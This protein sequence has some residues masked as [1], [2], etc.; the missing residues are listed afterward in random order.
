MG[1]RDRT[2]WK[3]RLA[4]V[5]FAL[6][7]A[8][9]SLEAASWV[10]WR[11]TSDEFQRLL[12]PHSDFGYFHEPDRRVEYSFW[13]VAGT[14]G[15]HDIRINAQGLRDGDRSYTKPAGTRRLLVLGDSIVFAAQVPQADRFT[16]LLQSEL[17]SG[18][19]G[20]S[21][22]VINAGVDG[23]GTGNELLYFRH[24]GFRY[25]PDVVILTFCIWPTPPCCRGRM[26]SGSSRSSR[27]AGC[28]AS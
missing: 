24:E 17:G 13:E 4:A 12:V 14:A 20:G 22:D 11:I 7:L 1:P 9:A 18:D 3:I 2:P 26:P 27:R 8:V 21:Y 6:V 19:P 25:Q 23:Y 10:L 16:D 28:P 15:A 5:L